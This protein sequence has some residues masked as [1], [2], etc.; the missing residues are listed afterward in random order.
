MGVT[1]T[2]I[3]DERSPVQD[4]DDDDDDDSLLHDNLSTILASSRLLLTLINNVLDLGKMEADK[5]QAIEVT[6]IPIMPSIQASIQFCEPFALL[7]D[8]RLVLDSSSNSSNSDED[9]RDLTILAN[10][11]RFEQILINLVSNGIKYTNK[12]TLVRI[13]IREASMEEAV[14]EALRAGTSDLKH[15]PDALQQA[16]VV[17][18]QEMVTIVSIRDQGRGILECEIANLFE[19]F[20]QLE[21]SKE[22][23]RHYGA[24]R[25]TC[26]TAVGQSSG[27]GLGLSLVLQFGTY[28]SFLAAVMPAADLSPTFRFLRNIIITCTG[29]SDKNGR[30][31]M[32]Q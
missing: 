31:C 12:D 9:C 3:M 25:G 21:I 30:P 22:M 11:L 2:M 15:R 23:D 19:E 29:N 27:S 18:K 24:S 13:S 10:Q 28:S 5:M 26:T 6:S 4:D 16:T 14:N 7:N 1:S 20:V 17:M 8:V 32:G